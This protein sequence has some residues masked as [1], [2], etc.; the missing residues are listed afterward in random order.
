[1]PLP[2]DCAVQV[3][4]KTLLDQ[5]AVAPDT[6]PL[7]VFEIAFSGILPRRGSGSKK[8]FQLALSCL[9]P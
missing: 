6:R 4:E 8:F 3:R 2:A 9:K 1:M 7:M 5:P